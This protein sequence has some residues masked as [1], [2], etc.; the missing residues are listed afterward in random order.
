MT[1]ELKPYDD[2][3]IAELER[4]SS[5]YA[6]LVVT[7]ENIKEAEKEA[8]A[9]MESEEVFT[10][11]TDEIPATY[12]PMPASQTP[13]SKPKHNDIQPI[14]PIGGA[15]KSN[16]YTFNHLGYLFTLDGRLTGHQCA[17]I[18]AAITDILDSEEVM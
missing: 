1:T 8:A 12:T 7:R 9:K 6:S 5:D 15:A 18:A 13:E 11:T 2:S 3:K 4:L 16:D 14:V 17:K 10:D